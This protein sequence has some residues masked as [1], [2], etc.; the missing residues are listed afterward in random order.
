MENTHYPQL[1][2]EQLHILQHSLGVD[3]YGQGRQYRN[4]F[5]TGKDSTDWP[6]CQMLVTH[7]LMKD[8]GPREL[9]G[10]MTTFTVTPRGIDAVAFLSPKP[11]KLSP[12]KARYREWLSVACDLGYSFIEWL[13]YKAEEKKAKECGFSSVHEYYEFLRA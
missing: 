9:A 10:G 5:V 12:G 2:S 6:W 3:Q 11:P 4:H 7:G 13:R 1:S 8:H